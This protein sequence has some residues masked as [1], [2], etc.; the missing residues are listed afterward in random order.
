M[1][2]PEETLTKIMKVLA[3]LLSQVDFLMQKAQSYQNC[4][5]S[6]PSF[7]GKNPEG[8]IFM[9]EK[10]FSLYHTPEAEK[11]M[12]AVISMTGEALSWYQY[13]E[14]SQEEVIT[15]WEELKE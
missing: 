4:K 9:A 10:Y 15:S 5:L 12:L 3:Q 11:V 6:L 14:E 2:I 13:W 8:W 1:L 7:S